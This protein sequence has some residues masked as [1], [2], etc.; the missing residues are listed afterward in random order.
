MIATSTVVMFGLMYLNVLETDQV[1]SETMAYNPTTSGSPEALASL[2][3]DPNSAPVALRRMARNNAEARSLSLAADRLEAGY[4]VSA[5]EGSDGR[6]EWAR[7][8][9]PL[10]ARAPSFTRH[11]HPSVF[12]RS[13]IRFRQWPA[14]FAAE[15]RM[16]RGRLQSPLEVLAV[17]DVV[18][19][20]SCPVVGAGAAPCPRR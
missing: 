5:V 19:Q 1:Y 11:W 2:L 3:Y 17:T 6:L 20:R 12:S 18:G 10:H 9:G 16:A 14:D 4:L 15:L 7:V 13:V 8:E